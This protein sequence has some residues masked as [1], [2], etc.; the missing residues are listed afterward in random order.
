MS[1]KIVFQNIGGSFQY[2]VNSPQDLKEIITLDPALWTALN[3]PLDCLNGDRKFLEYLDAD[4]NNMIRVDEVKNAVI[5]LFDVLKS[6]E[7]LND[8]SPAIN[9]SCLNQDSEAGKTLFDFTGSQL[10]D[11]LENGI[12]NLDKLSKKIVEVSSGPIKGDGIITLETAGEKSP[13][14]PLIKDLITVTGGIKN[15]AGQNGVNL[16]SLDKFVA[17][18]K[19]FLEWEK[20][21]EK[22]SLKNTD[23]AQIYPAF[24]GIK[25][26]IDEYFNFCE[27][28]RIDSAN[29]AR[30]KSEADTLPS[31]DINDRTAVE[32]AIKDAPLAHP[33]AKM[34]L[35]LKEGINPFYQDAVAQFA[36]VFTLS[37]LEIKTWQNLKT[38]MAPYEDYLSKAEGD[39]TGSLGSDKLE[40]Y[41][42]GQEIEALRKLL[43][44]DGALGSTIS[45][46]KALEKLILFKQYIITFVNNFVNFSELFNPATRS[47]IQAGSLVMDGRHF[48][49]SLK[50]KDINIHKKMAANSNLCM[51]YLELK[52]KKDGIEKTVNAVAAITS[53]CVFRIYQGK[54]G[55]FI[56]SEGKY[57]NATVI[58][59]VNG[60]ISFWQSVLLPFKKLIDIIS[61]RTQKLAS[62][63]NIGKTLETDLKAGSGKISSGLSAGSILVLCG[64]VGVAAIG[65]SVAYIIKSLEKVSWLKITAGLFIIALIILLPPVISALRKLRRRNLGMFMEAAG[66]AVNL[67]MR[68]NARVSGIFTYPSHYPNNSEFICYDLCSP[69]YNKIRRNGKTVPVLLIFAFSY[70]VLVAAAICWKTFA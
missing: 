19:A 68:L 24:S 41:I 4:C 27:L 20:N 43:D 32:A 10:T 47:M 22:P 3:A 31:L 8:K 36:E 37:S 23:P 25:Q 1:G 61:D 11:V 40:A 18:A 39:K 44:A 14:C 5:W 35:N 45:N 13:A 15:A 46:L 21:T 57:W 2:L 63:D 65:S 58:D 50:I 69:Y 67:T 56:D 64:G 52:Q 12:L 9:I 53:G 30:F 42:N 29:N 70:T 54:P 34:I 48:D 38:G 66:W 51:I 62:F 6:P 49:L 55:V 33:D 17:D 16:E 60:P 59:F 28:V 7:L 26:K